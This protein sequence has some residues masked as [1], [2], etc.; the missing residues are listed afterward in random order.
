MPSLNQSLLWGFSP[1]GRLTLLALKEKSRYP[2][3]SVARAAGVVD[4]PKPT[5]IS[6]KART[7]QSLRGRD[8]A[9]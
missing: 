6:R 5:T 9:T 1:V 8:M 7:L 4:Q 2:A 3:S